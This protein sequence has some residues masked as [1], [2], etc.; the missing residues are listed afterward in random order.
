M[1]TERMMLV[2]LSSLPNL[3]VF[4]FPKHLLFKEFLTR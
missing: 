3:V 4:L 1:L 2:S